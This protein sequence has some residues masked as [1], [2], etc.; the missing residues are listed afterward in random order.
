MIEIISHRGICDSNESSLLG[1]QNCVNLGFG[2]ELDLRGYNNLLYVSHDFSEH[3]TPF[4]QVCE[5]LK[6]SMVRKAFHIKEHNALNDVIQTIKKFNLTN[7]FVFSTEKTELTTPPEIPTAN[8]INK[9]PKNTI[10]QIL[11]CDE[12]VEK[13]FTREIINDLQKNGKLIFAH[14]LELIQK[15]NM[16]QIKEEWGRLIELNV[17]AI[18][19]NFPKECESYFGGMLK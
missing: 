4:N 7:F 19:T 8:Y 15:C 16:S 13:W 2:V 14:S 5:I 17:N 12:T 11:W 10:S 3:G 1:I 9:L 18:C 6:K